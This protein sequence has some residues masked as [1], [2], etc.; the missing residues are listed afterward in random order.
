MR[1]RVGA[2]SSVNALT[3]LSI[4]VYARNGRRN[5]QPSPSARRSERQVLRA[6][7]S[8]CLRNTRGLSGNVD[9]T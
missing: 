3:A 9:Q 6:Q 1:A 4:M 7:R 2:T 8:R 5:A